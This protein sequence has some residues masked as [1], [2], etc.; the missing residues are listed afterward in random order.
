MANKIIK[1]KTLNSY[2]HSL[3][4]LTLGLLVIS[5][6]TFFVEKSFAETVKVPVSQQG[7][8]VETPRTGQSMQQTESHFGQPIEKIAAIGEPPITRWRYSQF[9]V[10]FE[11]NKVIHA[12]IHSS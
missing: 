7:D 10:Y 8:A 4:A 9:T 5:S 2:K 11:H 6:T 3:K 1:N 12:V